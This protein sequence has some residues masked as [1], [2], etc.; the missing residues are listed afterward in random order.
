[1]TLL[2]PWKIGPPESPKHVPPRPVPPPGLLVKLAEMPAGMPEVPLT[3]MSFTY[4][5]D[6]ITGGGNQRIGLT[7]FNFDVCS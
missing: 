5:N 1:M 7:N 6:T 3:S 2:S 4:R